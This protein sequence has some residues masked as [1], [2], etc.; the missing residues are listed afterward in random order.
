MRVVLWLFLAIVSLPFS[1]SAGLD[2]R[3]FYCFYSPQSVRSL[4]ALAFARNLAR[5]HRDIA[6]EE[7][8]VTVSPDNGALFREALEEFEIERPLVPLFVLGGRHIVGWEGDDPAFRERVTALITSYRETAGDNTFY[9]FY[10]YKCPHCRKARPFMLEW[11]RRY[12][13]I[14]FK[15]L[16]IVRNEENMKL[17]R[18]KA[19]VLGIEGAATPTFV[20]GDQYVVGFEP[21]AQDTEVEEMIRSHLSGSSRNRDAVTTITIPF[22][23]TLD[24]QVISLPSFTFLIGILDGI[25]PCAMWVLMFLLTLLV[26]TKSR[27]T[28]FMIGC[29]FVVASAVV[30]FLFMTA[31]LNI[32][33]FM[34][35]TTI[36]TVLLGI[37][38]IIMGLINVKDFF[39]FKKGVSLMIPEDAKGKLYDKMRR[40]M[41]SRSMILAFVG[42]VVLAFFV[43]LI[44]LGCTIGLPAIYTRVLSIQR[45]GT[46]AK[47]GYMALYNVYYVIPLA[48]IVALFMLSMRKFRLEERH[49]RVL[50]LVS[51]S[52]M[53]V[54]GILLIFKPEWLVF[55]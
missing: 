14:Q 7:V 49:A 29:V 53:L 25:N 40:I 5:A 44:E 11:E 22:I 30:Y 36:V 42:T 16:E 55:L 43:N 39:F 15:W 10:S 46:A 28:L 47:Y 3:V 17:F 9:F 31:W 45:I 8:D 41:G 4:E 37:V 54:L 20:L 38:A 50:K 32:F 18:R 21:G 19:E 51:G 1:L 13:Q 34:G 26:N 33:M 48:L 23:G 27:A 6:F 12:P 24:A 35:I 2:D 52:L